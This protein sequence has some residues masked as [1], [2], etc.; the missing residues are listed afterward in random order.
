MRFRLTIA[1]LA[2]TTLTACGGF[3]GKLN[4]LNWFKRSAPVAVVATETPADPRPLVANVLSMQIESYPGGAIV[5][6]TGLPPTQ[7]YWDAELVPQPVDENGTLVLEF[8]VFPPI[9]AAGVV[10]QQ[11]REITVA[12][13]LS[14]LKLEA[15]SQ[16]VVQG[17]QNARSSRR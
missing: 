13:T 8:H 7:G 9:A 6:A 5:R 10:N 11:S 17:S 12:Y 15:I 1:I 14:N 4:P 2:L 3:S 16:I